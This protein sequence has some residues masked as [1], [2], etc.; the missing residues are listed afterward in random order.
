MWLYPADRLAHDTRR[1]SYVQQPWLAQHVWREV[2]YIL[3]RKPQTRRNLLSAPVTLPLV[4]E[5]TY[6][7]K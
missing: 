2:R 5:F 3:P 4:R 6:P 7:L 1:F